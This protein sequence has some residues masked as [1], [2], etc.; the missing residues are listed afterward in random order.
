MEKL[1]LWE[2]NRSFTPADPGE[3]MKLQM[4]LCE[5]VKADMEN[6]IHTHWGINPGAGNGFAITDKDEKT[7]FASLAKFIPYVEFTVEPMLSIDE[8]IAVLKNLAQQM[9]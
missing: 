5:L 1:I 9:K 8:V 4:T 3:R 7:I 2:M 6:G